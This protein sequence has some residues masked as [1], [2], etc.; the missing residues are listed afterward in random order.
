MVFVFNVTMWLSACFVCLLSFC[1]LSLDT[2]WLESLIWDFVFYFLIQLATTDHLFFV[3]P[4][5]CCRVLC[6]IHV[7]STNVVKQVTLPFKGFR[8]FILTEQND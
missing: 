6:I 7:C 5:K 8:A 4:S 1:L 3:I 2:V